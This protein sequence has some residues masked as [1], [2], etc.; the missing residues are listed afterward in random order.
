MGGADVSLA[1]LHRLSQ[2]TNREILDDIART[3]RSIALLRSL[4]W[5]VAAFTIGVILT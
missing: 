1:G 3:Q 5:I 2:M 4:W